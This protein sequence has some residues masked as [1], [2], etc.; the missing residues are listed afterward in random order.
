MKRLFVEAPL[1]FEEAARWATDEELTT[2]RS[3]AAARGREYLAWRAIVRRELGRDTTIAYDPI[4]APILTN[5]PLHISVSHCQGRIAVGLSD[6]PCAVDIER[7][8]R[9][10]TQAIPRYLSP[11]EQRISP[12]PLFPAVAWC[13]K[14]TLYKYAGQRELDLLRNLRIDRISFPEFSAP[15]RDVQPETLCNA[16]CG[17]I[18]AHYTNI[19]QNPVRQSAD[20]TSPIMDPIAE[21]PIKVAKLNRTL[22][23]CQNNDCI[24][25]FLFD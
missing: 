7:I 3:F 16:P 14:E 5:H 25:V 17:T 9:D 21:S 1:P 13:T 8:G 24:V 19:D 18:Y 6:K 20:N 4:G 22:H 15:K 23:F 10:F 11:E 2:A 12:H